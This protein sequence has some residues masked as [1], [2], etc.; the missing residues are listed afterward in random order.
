MLLLLPKNKLSAYAHIYTIVI[1]DEHIK[2]TRQQGT[3]V[4]A[5][6]FVVSSRWT[7]IKQQQKRNSRSLRMDSYYERD[8]YR[9]FWPFACSIFHM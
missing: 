4:G 5:N 2:T 3:L 8:Q 9:T 7:W 6:I 1:F